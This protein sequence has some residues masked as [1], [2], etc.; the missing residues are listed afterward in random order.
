VAHKAHHVI[1]RI[2]KKKSHLMGE[3]F[4]CPETLFQKFK[5]FSGPAPR[6]IAE[7]FEYRIHTGLFQRCG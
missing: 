4:L 3:F 2:P 1:R 7:L 5:I 6:R